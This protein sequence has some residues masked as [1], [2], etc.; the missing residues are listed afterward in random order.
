M[1]YPDINISQITQGTNGVMNIFWEPDSSVDGAEGL[2]VSLNRF[3]TDG[4]LAKTVGINSL[5]ETQFVDVVHVQS[6]TS[7][8][9]EA[10]LLSGLEVVGRSRVAY[11][12]DGLSRPGKCEILSVSTTT[13]AGVRSLVIEVSKSPW[14]KHSAYTLAERWKPGHEPMMDDDYQHLTNSTIVIGKDFTTRRPAFQLMVR[15]EAQKEPGSRYHLPGEW[16]DFVSMQKPAKRKP[17]YSDVEK[18]DT[19]ALIDCNVPSD[20]SHVSV[21]IDGCEP[22][23]FTKTV[24]SGNRFEFDTCSLAVSDWHAVVHYDDGFSVTTKTA[25]THNSRTRFPLLV[26]AEEKEEVLHL[27]FNLRGREKNH[28]HGMFLAINGRAVR[29]FG[30][31]DMAPLMNVE[32]QTERL[33][34]G[35]WIQ[36]SSFSDYSSPAYEYRKPKKPKETD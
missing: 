28:Y 21:F 30:R 13:V 5:V 25:R 3:H 19:V 6:E 31:E 9:Y 10:T 4:S 20:C 7:L 26:E 22:Q 24:P 14:V 1:A 23:I 16:S 27:S 29:R 18:R 33:S 35:D 12:H 17:F 15:E 11:P 36:L 8:V 32:I 34:D 2:S